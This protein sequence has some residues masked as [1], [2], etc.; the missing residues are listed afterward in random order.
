MKME[1]SRNHVLLFTV[2]AYSILWQVDI[3]A[4]LIIFLFGEGIF[5]GIFLHLVGFGPF[6]AALILINRDNDNQLIEL[7]I[8]KLKNFKV[9]SKWYIVAI[10][11]PILTYLILRIIQIILGNESSVFET[12][13]F[14]LGFPLCV[15]IILSGIKEEPGWRGYLLPSLIKRYSTIY[16]SIIVGLIWAFWHFP[17]YLFGTRPLGQFPQFVFTVVAL[18]FIYS[19]L[20]IQSESIP[21]V[22][23]FHIMHN[24]AV[25]MLLDLDRDITFWNGGGFVYLLFAALIFYLY[26]PTM[27]N[28]RFGEQ[29][30]SMLEKEPSKI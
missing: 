25:Y 21:I 27:N 14:S 19:W 13:L 30:L 11:I 16:S 8:Y 12:G 1:Y 3:V 6:I 4:P 24:F 9:S 26:G 29:P 2:L 28:Y 7:Y 22:A 18:S 17:L 10:G 15:S 20:Y 5:F 23:I